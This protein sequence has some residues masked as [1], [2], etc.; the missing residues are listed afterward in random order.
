MSHPVY[1]PD[2]PFGTEEEA[3]ERW[4][5]RLWWAIVGAVGFTLGYYFRR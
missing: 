4:A 2:P 1:Y 3:W 5:D